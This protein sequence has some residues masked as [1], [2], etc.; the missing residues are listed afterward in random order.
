MKDDER[1]C[2]VWNAISKN[3][4]DLY[5]R[6]AH[7]D[8]FAG[9]WDEQQKAIDQKHQRIRE[10][11]DVIAKIKEDVEWGKASIDDQLLFGMPAE[12]AIK[13]RERRTN[14]VFISVLEAIKEITR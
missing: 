13:V 14:G 9:A 1:K 2:R 8:T 4:I 10:L 7:Q 5:E 12:E 11:E 6:M 3:Y